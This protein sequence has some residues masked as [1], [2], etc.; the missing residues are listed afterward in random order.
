[1]SFWHGSS[2]VDQVTR[3]TQDI[4]KSFSST[5]M[6]GDVFFDITATY[7]TVWDHVASWPHLQSTAIATW[8]ACGP[9]DH[10]DDWQSQ[11]H[12]YH[13]PTQTEW[14]WRSRMA[15]HRDPSWH[16]FLQHLHLW[17]ANHRLQKACMRWRPN[18]HVCW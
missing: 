15:S 10:G 18:N 2:T 16:P 13:R 14:V 17:S 7:D 4:E 5:K 11:L 6:P 1:V 8:Q 9:H 3:L 12:P